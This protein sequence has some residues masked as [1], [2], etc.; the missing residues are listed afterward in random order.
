LT[1]TVGVPVNF[2]ANGL[3]TAQLS[4]FVWTFDDGTPQQTTTSPS[5]SHSFTSKGIKNARVDVFGV[6][7]CQI[8]TA[9][10]TLDVI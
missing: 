5:I 8:G 1:P 3:G 10:V 9:A 6:T 4:K 7:G 2:T